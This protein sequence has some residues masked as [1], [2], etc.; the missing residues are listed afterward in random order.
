[1]TGQHR[2]PW[3]VLIVLLAAQAVMTVP[4]ATRPYRGD[5]LY[6]VAKARAIFNTGRLPKATAMQLAVEAGA[7]GDSDWR[8][9]GYALILVAISGGNFEAESLRPRVTVLQFAAM[10]AA[11]LLGFSL[12]GRQSFRVRLLAAIV[13]GIAPW[14]L[15]FVATAGPDS[16]NASLAF[17]ALL[18]LRRRETLAAGALLLTLTF[19]LRPEM[20]AVVPVPIGVA[21]LVHRVRPREW[22]LA[23][24]A[25]ALVVAAQYGYRTYFIGRVSTT[26]FGGLHIYNAGLFRWA[27]SWIGTEDEAYDFVYGMNGGDPTGELPSRAFANERERQIVAQLRAET[28]ARGFSQDIDRR[29]GE[30]ADRRIREHPITAGVAPRLWHTVHLWL[31]AETND[32]LLHGWI[33]VPRP[34][35]RVLLALLLLL[36]A[37]LVL[38]LPIAVFATRKRWLAEPVIPILAAHVIARTLLIGV[39]LNW[40]VYRYM[41]TA[42]LPLLLVVFLAPRTRA[43]AIS[44]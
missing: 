21:L 36:K 25:F 7:W 3:L 38:A 24:G 2:G 23:I 5:E 34:L 41:V 33:P 16:L 44:S 6:Y 4:I 42:W 32:Q 10:A 8:P 40:M 18:L 29:F 14:P 30:L 1:M 39:V 9:P 13:I 27:N 11:I 19:L 12:L 35:R 15:A 43:P 28:R 20:I 22:A 26:L 37:A 31:N 17:F